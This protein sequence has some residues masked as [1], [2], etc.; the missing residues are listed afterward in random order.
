MRS[1]AREGAKRVHRRRPRTEPL[2][3]SEAT[4]DDSDP[5][6]DCYPEAELI[7]RVTVREVFPNCPSY[8]HKLALVE[9]SRF[10]PKS[11]CVTPVPSWKRTDWASDV[12]PEGA[13]ARDEARESLKR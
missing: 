4:V 3:R 11:D 13:P 9:R 12:L 7:V 5:L 8:I 1:P 10:V 6:L 2:S